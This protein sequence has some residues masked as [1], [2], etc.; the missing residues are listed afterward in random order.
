VNVL[1]IIVDDLKPDLGCYGN[2]AVVSPN[3]D[4]LAKRGVVFERAYCQQ[5]VCAPS[6]ASFLTGLR[7]DST[8]V[9]D[10]KTPVRTALP[11]VVTLP[12]RFKQ[13]GYEAVALGKVYHHGQ[14]DWPQ[15][16][17]QA[18]WRPKHDAPGN[19]PSGNDEVSDEDGPRPKRGAPAVALDLPETEFGDGQ[20]AERAVKKLDELKDGGKPFF[21]AVGISKPHLP[22]VSPKKYW[23]LYDPATLALADNPQPP[24]G[25]P[26]VAMHNFAE[27]RQYVGIPKKGPVSEETARQL[28][29]GYR[30]ATSFA[31]AQVGKVLGEL[32]RLGLREKTVVV[33][34]GDH[35]WHLGDHGL[36]T[37]HTNFESATHAP[38]IVSAPGMSAGAKSAALV[39]LVDVYP[40]LCELTGIEATKGLEGTSLARLLREPARAWKTAAFSQF[41][42]EGR[43]GHS[44]TDGRF[45]FT[46]WEGKGGKAA[47]YELYDHEADPG[48]N[49][50]LAGEAG[51]R[52]TVERMEGMLEGGWRKAAP[53]VEVSAPAR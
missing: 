39:E 53:A 2:R 7:P 19:N 45:R 13:A 1:L 9:F 23:D 6:R 43:M 36:W 16:W 47:E 44:V 22:F 33:L 52:E 26:G 25:V 24:Q 21:L 37:K 30:A 5:A 17:T 28:V 18:P 12:Q 27:L 20:T 14:D 15:G 10:L 35:G 29:W 34:L 11:D 31:D 40:T 4:A 51:R 46:K 38:L 49:V 32:D 8:K 48:E 50:N 42:H 3:I 41:P